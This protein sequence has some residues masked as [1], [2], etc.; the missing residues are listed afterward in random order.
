MPITEVTV[1]PPELQ[2]ALVALWEGSVQASQ[3][4]FKRGPNRP[5]QALRPPGPGSSRA[6]AGGGPLDQPQGFMG[7]TGQKL[8]MLFVAAD[9][10]GQ[11][12]GSALLD[13]GIA[14]FGVNQVVVN[15]QN[16]AA[17]A[18][19]HH[20]GF[21]VYGRHALDEQGQPYPILLMQRKN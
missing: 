15:E 13:Y 20:H 21:R 16:P 2:A 14:H 19:Y 3:P 4:L 8:E 10:R 1:R 5:N 11:G 7:I 18:F 9:Q 6:P 17:Q 12:I